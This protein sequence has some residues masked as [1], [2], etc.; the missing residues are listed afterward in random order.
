M[1]SYFFA[2]IAKRSKK[3]NFK[4]YFIDD[5]TACMDDINMLSFLDLLKYQMMERKNME[6]VFF[7]TCDDRIC[8][9]L[10]YKLDGCGV[11]YCE[12]GEEK[13]NFI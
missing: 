13:L 3:E 1:L 5:L 7:L 6:Q 11:K 8:R 10:R 4:V 2:G 9:L 12:I